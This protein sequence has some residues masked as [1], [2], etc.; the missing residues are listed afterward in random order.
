MG[1]AI[2]G[3]PK[4]TV[5]L[6]LGA[7]ALIWQ[8][9]TSRG[10]QPATAPVR[11]RLTVVRDLYPASGPV[12]VRLTLDNVS[13]RPLVLPRAVAVVPKFREPAVPEFPDLVIVPT[14]TDSQGRP[15]SRD[16][17]D[18]LG[19]RTVVPESF[20]VLGP[21]A[22]T[23]LAWDLTRFPWQYSFL[24]E[25]RYTLK[26]RLYFVLPQWLARERKN[27]SWLVTPEALTYL[28]AHRAELSSGAV[29]TAATELRICVPGPY[30]ACPAAP[31]D[32]SA[33]AC[34]Q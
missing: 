31:R 16:S 30:K 34:A 23:T 32:S 29:E 24:K 10:A 28:E 3:F 22:S 33:A 27:K 5:P 14:L 7:A 6:L 18:L 20:A 9:G 19:T 17:R 2:R 4:R 11:A 21:A 13:G 8:A 15:V 25:G 12:C 1:V 26:L